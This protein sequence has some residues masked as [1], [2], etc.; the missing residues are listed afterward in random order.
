MMPGRRRIPTMP[1]SNPRHIV[2]DSVFVVFAK[3]CPESAVGM[4]IEQSIRHRSR[5]PAS[6][7]STDPAIGRVRTEQKLSEEHFRRNQRNHL[8][9]RTARGK[10]LVQLIVRYDLF[11]PLHHRRADNDTARSPTRARTATVRRRRILS[12]RKRFRTFMPSAHLMVAAGAAVGAAALVAL[13][14]LS[15]ARGDAASH[16]CDRVPSRASEQ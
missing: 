10:S 16:R 14:G 8:L 11:I 7:A 2:L 9:R 13:T 4:R 5:G 3:V 6:T 15:P 12:R 1:Y